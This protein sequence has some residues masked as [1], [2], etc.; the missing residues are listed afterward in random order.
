MFNTKNTSLLLLLCSLTLTLSQI[1]STSWCNANSVYYGYFIDDTNNWH[2]CVYEM[3]GSWLFTYG[4]ICFN[5]WGT[6][7]FFLDFAKTRDEWRQ[8]RTINLSR[9][10][11]LLSL[12]SINGMLE[13]LGNA[14][15]RPDTQAPIY[16]VYDYFWYLFP[17]ALGILLVATWS[18]INKVELLFTLN[19]RKGY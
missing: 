6:I 5:A 16:F 8:T 13:V 3:P 10:G 4:A 18:I 19:K 7:Y 11:L 17:A 15:Q 12:S 1:V 9:I 14:W 2:S